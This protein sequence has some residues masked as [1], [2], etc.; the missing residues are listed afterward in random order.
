MSFHFDYD[1]DPDFDFDGASQKSVNY[2]RG[3]MKDAAKYAIFEIVTKLD[4]TQRRYLD[5]L[6]N[7]WT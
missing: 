4:E 7:I 1:C 2:F 5:L 3:T 6:S